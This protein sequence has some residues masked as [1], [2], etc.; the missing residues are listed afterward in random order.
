MQQGPCQFAIIG[1]FQRFGGNRITS[2]M[3]YARDSCAAA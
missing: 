3:N 2:L 1:E